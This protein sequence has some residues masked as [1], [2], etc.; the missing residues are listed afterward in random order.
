MAAGSRLHRHRV[1]LSF[2]PISH[3]GCH[4]RRCWAWTKLL[5]HERTNELQQSAGRHGRAM[6]FGYHGKHQRGEIPV[7]HADRF[8]VSAPFKDDFFVTRE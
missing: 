4:E 3:V 7:A 6:E 8:G 5:P 1:V 2:A